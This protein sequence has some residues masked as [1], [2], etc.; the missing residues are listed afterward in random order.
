MGRKR[1]LTIITAIAALFGAFL[2]ST[3]K[4]RAW[5]SLTALTASGFV[6][7]TLV[8]AAL[9]WMDAG[10]EADRARLVLSVAGARPED[11]WA[12][13]LA[14]GLSAM[15]AGWLV[16]RGAARPGQTRAFDNAALVTD[17]G[18]RIDTLLNR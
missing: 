7:A 10:G 8:L 11:L 16:K 6:H 5:A 2:G 17:Y 4:N 12:S 13:V 3:F 14:G 15:I 1:R 18:Q 9:A